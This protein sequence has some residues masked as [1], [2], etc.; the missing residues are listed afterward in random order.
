MHRK[1]RLRLA[2]TNLGTLKTGW[3]G[4]GIERLSSDVQGIVHRAGPVLE[5]VAANAPGDTA[6]EHDQR[7]LRRML[8]RQGIVEFSDRERRV[9]VHLAI[10]LRVSLARRR[11][12]HVSALELRHQ[13]VDLR[14]MPGH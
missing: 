9:C 12:E 8:G 6:N 7:Q 14:A 5:G 11:H 13:A 1:N 3:Y 10:A 4:P 2:R